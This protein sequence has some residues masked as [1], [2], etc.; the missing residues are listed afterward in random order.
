VDVLVKSL[1]SEQK[2][3]RDDKAA[4]PV[5]REKKKTNH[6]PIFTKGKERSKLPEKKVKNVTEARRTNNIDFSLEPLPY[7][8]NQKEQSMPTT[9]KE[10]SAK[11]GVKEKRVTSTPGHDGSMIPAGEITIITADGKSP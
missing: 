4:S 2:S 7:Y 10:I 11:G 3:S 9:G 6:Y 1:A 8:R 5:T